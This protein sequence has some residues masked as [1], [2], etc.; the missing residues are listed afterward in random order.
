MSE[1]EKYPDAAEFQDQPG[2]FGIRNDFSFPAK[3]R[4]IVE[5]YGLVSV[6]FGDLDKF[7]PVN[8]VYGHDV[9]DAVIKAALET[10]QGVLG[11]DGELFHPSGDE[12]IMLLPNHDEAKAREVGERIRAAIEQYEF[13]TI[14]QGFVTTTIGFATYPETCGQWEEVKKSADLTAMN[15][16]KV[17]RNRVVSCSE[18]IEAIPHVSVEDLAI[19]QLE[20]QRIDV[21]NEGRPQT[22]LDKA[23]AKLQ[24]IL[25]LER[26]VKQLQ[27]EKRPRMAWKLQRQIEGITTEGRVSTSLQQKADKL[28]DIDAEIGA[29]KEEA[30]RKK[31]DR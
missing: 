9:G 5:K 21:L 28:N 30:E 24:K 23:R 3:L 17:K 4:F 6:L 26:L 7:K 10:V 20:I 27:N 19:A 11:R 18:K 14:G 12:M 16:K 15:A 22:D 13:P 2:K 25:T 8:D 1:P 29:L 31:G